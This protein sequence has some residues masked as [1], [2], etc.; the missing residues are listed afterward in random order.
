MDYYKILN[1]NESAT[2]KEIEQ[3]YKDLYSFYN[4]ENNVSKNAY[5]KFREVNEAYRVLS[6]IK[7]KEMYDRLHVVSEEEKEI[8]KGELVDVNSY[9]SSKINVYKDYN[10]PISSNYDP[11]N[12]YLKVSLSYLYYLTGSDYEVSYLKKKLAQHQ[13]SLFAKKD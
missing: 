9:L 2:L 7:Q 10:E 1:L 6:E 5:K 12:I 3:A 4:P 11:R 8:I 13:L